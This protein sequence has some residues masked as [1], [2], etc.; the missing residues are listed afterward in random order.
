MSGTRDDLS[1]P[2]VQKTPPGRQR[3]VCLLS[4]LPYYHHA[5]LALDT[6]GLLER[7]LHDPTLLNALPG[8][9]LPGVGP[10]VERVNRSRIAPRLEGLPDRWLLVGR[11]GS[12]LVPV[13]ERLV[14]PRHVP[15]ERGAGLALQSL[16]WDRDARWQLGD[17]S[18]L[19]FVSGIGEHSAR[20][21]LARGGQVICDVRAPHALTHMATTVPWLAA[22]GVRYRLPNEVNLPRLEREYRL[23][24]LIICNSGY[25]RRSFLE[26][27][28]GPD[29]VVSVPYGC[30]ASC[31]RPA[32]AHPRSFTALFVGRER[33]RKG[34]LDLADAA[35][36]LRSSSSLLV[37]G[38]PDGISSQALSRLDARVEFLG[39]VAP[40][41]MPAVY[42]RASVLVLPSLSEG[43]GL[44]VT[45]AMAAGLPVVVSDHTGAAEL[46]TDGKDGFVVP[47]GDVAAIADR[48]GALEADP[49]RC[50][51]M[52][53]AARHVAVANDWTE[54]GR[55]LTEVYDMLVL[56]R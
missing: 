13:I 26:Q 38:A 19:H 39:P 25:T 45:E 27:G 15:P 21:V 44:V 52:G 37:T 10:F 34:F 47:A 4:H 24:D 32:T 54:Y 50:A 55:Q 22:R 51:A 53:A 36:S 17:P 1:A 30:D 41:L 56:G 28:F 43:F 8:A 29:R 42:R 20:R 16:L 33:L 23:A 49:D 12:A 3:Q 5:A 2:P 11:L 9:S 14:S 46:V 40:D 35:R 48:L 31:F 6:A 18:V 7:Y